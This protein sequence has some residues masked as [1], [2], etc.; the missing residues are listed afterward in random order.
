MASSQLHH[1]VP[2]FLLRRFGRGKMH[3]LHT[4]DKSTGTAFS[5]AAAKLAALSDFYDFNFMG[6]PMTIEPVLA[7]VEASAGAHIARIVKNRRL[8]LA[9][10]VERGEL[11]AFFAI[12]LV[13]TPANHATSAELF[14]RMEAWLRRQGMP[15]AFFAPDPLIGAGEN[16]VRAQMARRIVSAP[17]DYGPALIEKDWVLLETE[18]HCPYLIGD[19]PLVMH[20]DRPAGLR[21][22]VGLSVEGIEIYFPLSPDLALALLC[23]SIGNLIQANLA[24]MRESYASTDFSQS[25]R[26]LNAMESG[27]P[28]HVGSEGSIF[29]NALQIAHAERFVFSSDG[30]FEL[31]ESML[32]ND[33]TLQR[34]LRMTEATG[35]F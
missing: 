35:K 10:P 7:D 17:S 14:G 23:P 19:H 12:Q 34:G 16:A 20:N 15:E 4:F 8:N 25:S 30:N 9:D 11:A 6:Q 21:G 29:I 28:M 24:T 1:Y 2:R 3:Q 13:R 27:T 18:P 32:K 5:R 22:N 26:L 31:V 33:P